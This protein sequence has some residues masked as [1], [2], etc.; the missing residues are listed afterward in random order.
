MAEG[1][2]MP[3]PDQFIHHYLEPH[4]ESFCRVCARQV[5]MAKEESGLIRKEKNHVCDPYFV[6]MFRKH[7]MGLSSSSSGFTRFQTETL[8]NIPEVPASIEFPG[9][10]W[11]KESFTLATK[12]KLPGCQK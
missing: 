6:E 10:T 1:F 3:I 8:P 7:A 12:R 4:Y 2:P 5:G 9:K 11:L